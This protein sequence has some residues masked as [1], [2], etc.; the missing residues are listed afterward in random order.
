MNPLLI[1]FLGYT[2]PALVAGVAVNVLPRGKGRLNIRNVII[3]NVALVVAIIINQYFIYTLGLTFPWFPNLLSFVAYVGVVLLTTSLLGSV[4]FWYG[5]SAF[6][7]QLTM[8]SVT[9]M[10]LSTYPLHLIILLIVPLYSCCHLLHARK[11]ILRVALFLIWGSLSILIFSIW[12]NIF[13]NTALHTLFG[14]LLIYKS[15]IYPE[16]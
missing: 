14:A 5:M 7:Q 6:V 1:W 9:F 3:V 4:G 16:E 10:L 11:R 8:L 13:L 2:L 12:R 15:L